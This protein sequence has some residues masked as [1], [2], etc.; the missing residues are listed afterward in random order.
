MH[1]ESFGRTLKERRKALDLTQHMLADLVGCAVITLKKIEADARRP[2]RDLAARLGIHLRVAPAEREAWILQARSTGTRTLPVPAHVPPAWPALALPSVPRPAEMA[3]LAAL[4]C[5]PT[6][7]LVTVVGPPGVGKTQCA[8]QT[9]PSVAA[10]FPGGVWWLSLAALHDAALVIPT[11]VQQ[12][13]LSLHTQP[14]T[15]APHPAA[16]LVVLDTFDHLMSA[17]AQLA[18]L[19]AAAPHLTLLVTSREYLQLSIE[20]VVRVPPLALP[21]SS[22]LDVVQ[23]LENPAVQ[24]FAARAAAVCPG[25]ALTADNVAVV[26]ALCRHLEGVPLALEL[27]A[28]Q[29]QLLSPHAMRTQVSRLE[30]LVDGPRDLPLR[31]QTMRACLDWSYS[32]LAAHEQRLLLALTLFQGECSRVA[33]ERVL[34]DVAGG[35]LTPALIR[36]GLGSLYSKSLIE[37]HD[38][39]DGEPRFGMLDIIRD[40][41]WMQLAADSDLCGFQHDH[42]AYHCELS[43]TT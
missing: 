23:A 4:V 16:T 5:D 43:I 12:L 41:A 39:P 30:L 24:L 7:R 15:H 37:R 38:R 33:V 20:R 11:I 3:R 10:H 32:R 31:Q 8:L 25:W 14:V 36:Q 29:S 6:T 40:Y 2:S 1:S 9:L 35:T 17:A 21:A 22:L 19:L 42:A 34:D 28:A 18:A 27:A 13:G 26:V